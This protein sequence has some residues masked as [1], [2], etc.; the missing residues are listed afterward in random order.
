MMPTAGNNTTEN[1]E[2]TETGSL[3]CRFITAA[4]FFR[5]QA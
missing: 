3:P 4:S 2:V 1:T 5:K